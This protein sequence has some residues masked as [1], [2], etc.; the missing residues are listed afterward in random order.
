M[1]IAILLAKLIECANQ[2]EDI[3]TTEYQS[4]VVIH[5]EENDL[6]PFDID[7]IEITNICSEWMVEIYSRKALK[8]N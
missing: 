1:N 6:F 8:W 7:R 3:Q 2:P 4:R 5:N